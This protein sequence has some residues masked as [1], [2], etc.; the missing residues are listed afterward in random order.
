MSRL[1]LILSDLYLPFGT[2]PS[3][4]EWPSLPRLEHFEWLLRIASRQGSVR[5]WRTA[6]CASAGRP[7]FSRL[8]PAE[9]A[10]RGRIPEPAAAASW[11]ATPVHLEARLDHVRLS[12]AGLLSL[13]PDERA[14]WCSEFS[15]AFGPDLALIEAGARGFLLSGLPTLRARTL[16]PAFLLGA[17]IMPGL[18]Q[19]PDATVLRRLGAEIDMW[20]HGSELNRDREKRRRPVISSLWLWGGNADPAPPS[21][22][23]AGYASLALA[24]DDSVLAGLSREVTGAEP[25]PVPES[26]DDFAAAADHRIVEL[27]PMTNP[28]QS[29]ALV[30][31]RWFG[32]A[33]AALTRG[34]LDRIDIL[35]NERAFH[36]TRQHRFA[37]WRPRR[38]WIATIGRAFRPEA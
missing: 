35:A 36:V 15:R 10:A 9:V 30:D 29:L 18:P 20:L 23:P 26:L 6:I 1:T 7:D 34:T 13:A 24:G 33:R 3:D 4:R 8:A 31:A 19:G 32:P 28:S 37:F 17:D 25:I 5:P 16:D 14:A 27:T 12:N 22:F 2:G 38:P 21:A 11:L